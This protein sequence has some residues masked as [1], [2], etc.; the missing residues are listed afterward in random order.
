[1]K[2]ERV[3]LPNILTFTNL[4]FGF[5]AIIFILQGRF[6][7][8]AWLVVA[9]SILDGLDGTIARLIKSSSRFGAEMD[10]LADVVS[11]GVTP[12]LLV[13]QLL[14]QSLG[15]YSIIFAFSLLMAGAARLARYN[16]IHQLRPNF[17]GFVG[18]PIPSGALVI[19]GFYLY[20]NHNPEGISTLPIWFILVP[21][22]SLLEISTFQYQRIPIFSIPNPKHPFQLVALIII[23]ITCIIFKPEKVIFPIMSIY[24]LTGP[25]GWFMDFLKRTRSIGDE[26]EKRASVIY[27]NKLN[28]RRDRR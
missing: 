23:V 4:L 26:T 1:M 14:Y 16:I 27:H 12:S 13:Y 25:L 17:H 7:S 24:L 9:S 22:V 5:L 18:L 11:F 10:S 28:R 15:G 8:A 6:I 19:I 3:I 20:S 2:V 21:L